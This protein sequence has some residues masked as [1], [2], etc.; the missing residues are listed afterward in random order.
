MGLPAWRACRGRRP[1]PAPLA[2][3]R[4]VHAVL[5][6]GARGALRHRRGGARPRLPAG[7]LGGAGGLPRGRGDVHPPHRPHGALQRARACAAAAAA[8]RGEDGG[9]AAGEAHRGSV[10]RAF[11]PPSRERGQILPLRPWAHPPL[12]D[13]A[14]GS[15]RT[16]PRCTRSRRSCRRCCRSGRSSSSSRSAPSSTTCARCSCRQTR[17]SSTPRRA[18]PP[19]PPLPPHAP[20]PERPRVAAR[21]CG[22]G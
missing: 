8:V 5:P 1:L 22:C 17:R 16:P 9:A 20:V 21:C 7:E 19:P 14:G 10:G 11:D 12:P 6:E 13:S 18:P 3:A 15:H 2:Q 4:R